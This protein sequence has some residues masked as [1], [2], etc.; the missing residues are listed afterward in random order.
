MKFTGRTAVLV[1]VASVSA[2]AGVNACSMASQDSYGPFAS[3]EAA[4]AA[5]DKRTADASA[6][7]SLAPAPK[8]GSLLCHLTAQNCVPD[9]PSCSA[10]GPDEITIV[11]ASTRADSGKTSPVPPSADGGTGLAPGDLDA[12]GTDVGDATA[13]ESGACRLTSTSTGTSGDRGIGFSCGLSGAGVD[14]DSCASGDACKAGFECVRDPKL[15]SAGVCRQYCC[16]GTCPGGTG[17]GN[18]TGTFCDIQFARTSGLKVP[19]CMPVRSCKLLSASICGS[20]QTCAVVRDNDGTTGCVDLG[21]AAVGQSCEQV[22]C[23]TG[24]TCLGVPGTRKCSQLCS[25]ELPCPTG[26]RCLSSPPTFKEPGVGICV[27][28]NAEP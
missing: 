7:G 22:H 11:D 16:T 10:A 9:R 25:K 23:D 4:P 2:A 19:V 3:G 18:G 24:L 21:P 8:R 28:T 1:C 17:T 5:G 15:S 13:L 6:A 20:T 26:E 12:S 27:N 14:G